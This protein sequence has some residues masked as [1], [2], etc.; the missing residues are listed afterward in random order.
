MS[1][2]KE[3][4]NIGIS[5]KEEKKIMC[6]LHTVL[7]EYLYEWMWKDNVAQKDFLKV[8]ELIKLWFL[9]Q[10]HSVYSVV[11]EKGSAFFG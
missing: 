11:I 10:A 2:P 6:F 3:L 1:I 9:F 4:N 5:L 8:L 7:Q